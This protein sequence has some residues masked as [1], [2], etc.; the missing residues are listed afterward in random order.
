MAEKQVWFITGAG[1]GL[2]IDIAQTALAAGHSVVATGRNPERVL[3]AIG[4]HDNLLTVALDIT[5]PAAAQAAAQAAVDRFGRIDVL[6]NNAGN[7]YAGYFENISPE[8]FRAQMETNF[9]GPLNVTRAILPI[10]RAQRSGQVITVTS[11]GRPDRAGVRRRLRRIEVRPRRLDGVDP[12]RPRAL[13]HQDDGRRAGLLPHR[14]AGRGRVDDLAGAGDRGLR[15]AHRADHR[16]VE[17]HERSAGRRPDA[18][19]R[20]RS[21]RCPTPGSCRC[22]S[23]PAPTAWRAK[24]RTSPPSRPRS[25]RT[26]SCRRRS[27]TTS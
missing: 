1:R 12:L 21:S 17:G 6:V 9:F 2:G 27:P 24:S 14:A 15:R 3:D 22:G 13:R 19:S 25:T 18:S 11:T 10:M 20:R 23:S 7:F 26:A 8:Q 5:D 4:A 16:G